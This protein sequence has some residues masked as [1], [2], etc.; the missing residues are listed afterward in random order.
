MT[1]KVASEF[2]F[3]VKVLPVDSG[4]WEWQGARN[5]YG[6]GCFSTKLNP[7]GLAHRFAYETFV[8]S[9]Q[10]MCVLHKC[11]NP[12]C[13]RPD[14]LRLGTTK[15]NSDDMMARGR[16]RN[17]NTNKTHCKYGHA[18]TADNIYASGGKRNCRTCGI[19][20]HRQKR[21]AA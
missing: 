10:G 16:N 18:L 11:D 8:G 17:Q 21:G 13:V 5:N 1:T 15:E 20:W 2:R 14:H 9:A 19:E 4:C 12:R 6:Y 3:W 7:C